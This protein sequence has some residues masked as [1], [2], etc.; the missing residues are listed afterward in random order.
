MDVI[1]H[2]VPVILALIAAIPGVLAFVRQLRKDQ[3][4]TATIQEEL[5]QE[6]RAELVQYKAELER[7]IWEQAQ[8]MI[9]AQSTENAELRERIRALEYRL[10]ELDAIRQELEIENEQLRL[11]IAEWSDKV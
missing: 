10:D 1:N 4:E 9:R 5:R 3:Q 2:Y 8:V 7:T 6:Y 11:I